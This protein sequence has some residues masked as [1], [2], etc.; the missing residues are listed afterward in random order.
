M[1][2]YAK[3]VDT[4]EARAFF[5]AQ[6]RIP[7]SVKIQHCEYS[8]WLVLN[9]PPESIVIP[10]IAIIEGEMELPMGKV[11][12]DYLINYKLGPHPMLPK[13]L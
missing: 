5:R 1:D 6:Y 9:R 4:H 11:T 3:L 12:K 8:E 13:C 2:R 10:M 7:N